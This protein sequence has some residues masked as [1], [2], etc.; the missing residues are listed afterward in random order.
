MYVSTILMH[1]SPPVNAVFLSAALIRLTEDPNVSMPDIVGMLSERL[2]NS[3]WVVVFKALITTHNLMVLGNEVGILHHTYVR[4]CIQLKLNFR[5]P[6][7]I[8]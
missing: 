6:V 5:R 7:L 2:R 4:T 8:L 3:N 1:F